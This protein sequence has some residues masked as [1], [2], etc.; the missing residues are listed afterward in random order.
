M[1]QWVIGFLT[2]DIS[3]DIHKC[4]AELIKLTRGLA[5]ILINC[6]GLDKE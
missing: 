1:E 2:D 3:P 5:W 4:N 6:A